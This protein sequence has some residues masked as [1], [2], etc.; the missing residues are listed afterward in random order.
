MNLFCACLDTRIAKF[1]VYNVH[2]MGDE[3]MVVSGMPNKNGWYS[4]NIYII[5]YSFCN[6][7]NSRRRQAHCRDCCHVIG[8]VGRNG[9]FSD[10]SQAKLQTVYEDGNSFRICRRGRCRVK[11][12]EILVGSFI[13]KTS[14]VMISINAIVCFSVMGEATSIAHMVE[15]MGEGMRIHMSAKAKHLLDKVG[16]FRTEFRGS[17]DMGV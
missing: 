7:M 10:P 13:V 14:Y 11:D 9:R 1:N 3:I 6:S 17:L 12:S 8:L 2:T 15:K 4:T 16:G 5:I